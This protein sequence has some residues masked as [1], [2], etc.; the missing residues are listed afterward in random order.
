MIIELLFKRY[1]T[2]KGIFVKFEID[3]SNMPKL[4]IIVILYE[5]TNLPYPNYGKAMLFIIR[6]LQ[7]QEWKRRVAS[8][9]T[10]YLTAKIINPESLKSI[11]QY[12]NA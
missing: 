2:A 10:M 6:N 5:R 11:G 7:I 4:T 8:L 3:N 12:L 9:F 1:L